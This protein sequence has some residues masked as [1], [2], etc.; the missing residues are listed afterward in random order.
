MSYDEHDA[1]MDEMYERMSDELYPEHRERAIEEFTT[2]RFHSYYKQHSFVMR[3]AVDMLQEGNRLRDTGH[4]AAAV[5]FYASAVELLL[6]ATVLRPVMAGLIHN[7]KLADV[8]VKHT[9]TGTGYARYSQLLSGI[10]DELASINLQTIS[11][12]GQKPLLEECTDLRRLRNDVIHE[13][14]TRTVADAD[15]GNAVVNAVFNLLVNPMLYAL[16][17]T[18]VER[19]EIREATAVY[20]K[21]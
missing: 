5:I 10:F 9:L 6:K 7:D 16:G 3:P 4:S 19:G 17:L 8:V 13:G 11:R 2:E 18:V 15:F 21:V 12:E 20:G 1:A 14:T